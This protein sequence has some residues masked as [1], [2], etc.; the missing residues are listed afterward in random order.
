LAAN[1]HNTQPWIFTASSNKIVIAPD[2]ARRCPAVDPDD[3]HLFVSLGCAAENLIVAASALGLRAG[4]LVDDDRIVVDLERAP[5][6]KSTL[7]EAIPARQ[8]TR[9]KFDGR[10]VASDA[11]RLLESACS[12]PGVSV[13]IMTDRGRISNIV[14]YVLQGNSAQ[15]LTRHSWSNS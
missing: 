3:H 13:F 14:D 7:V 4:P 6:E 5:C 12:D 11:L 10:P 2:F 8:S 9:A 1:S 15:C